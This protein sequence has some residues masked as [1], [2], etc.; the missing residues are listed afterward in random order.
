MNDLEG[1]LF[2]DNSSDDVLQ[3]RNI[4]VFGLII[5]EIRVKVTLKYTAARKF[6]LQVQARDFGPQGPPSVLVNRTKV[7]GAIECQ[8]LRLVGYNERINQA[9]HGAM[10]ES[11][12]VIKDLLSQI[13]PQVSTLFKYCESIALL[14]LLSSFA[15]STRDYAYKRPSINTDSYA[16]VGGRHPI[17]DSVR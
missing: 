9:V 12:E 11:D 4:N 2:R 8:T 6:Y 1:E 10:V 3:R 17:L 15:S 7:K 14:D 16:L 13:R 5:D